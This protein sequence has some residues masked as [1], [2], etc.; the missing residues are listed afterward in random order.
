MLFLLLPFIMVQTACKK[1]NTNNNNKNMNNLVVSNNFDWSTSTEGNFK[2]TALSNL[3]TPLSG[4]KVAI[5]SAN[6]ALISASLK[7]SLCVGT[8]ALQINCFIL[9][10]FQ[11]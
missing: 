3:G 8:C 9:I 4:V 7:Q 2:V 11:Y 10:T 6:P 5:Y 1:N